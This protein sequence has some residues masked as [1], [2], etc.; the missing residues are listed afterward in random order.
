MKEALENL[1]SFLPH[2][3]AFLVYETD[4]ASL[5]GE[6]EAH[7]LTDELIQVSN[8]DG[9]PVI[10]GVDC[11]KLTTKDKIDNCIKHYIEK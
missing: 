11:K 5:L 7:E 8:S 3:D 2:V 1:E 4:V 10:V 6:K 9:R